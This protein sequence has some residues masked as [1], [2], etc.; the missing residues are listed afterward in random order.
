MSALMG[1]LP[2]VAILSLDIDNVDFRFA[3]EMDFTGAV[4]NL[5]RTDFL[6]GSTTA[7]FVGGLAA[8]LL[9]L[10]DFNSD[11]LFANMNIPALDVG[12]SRL[13]AFGV[14]LDVAVE[15]GSLNTERLRNDF[16]NSILRFETLVFTT[17]TSILLVDVT[18]NG[19]AGMAIR[20]AE[21]C[22]WYRD[23]LVKGTIAARATATMFLLLVFFPLNLLVHGIY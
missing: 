23:G 7:N 6:L 15:V 14:N 3:I 1:L 12:S 10:K 9:R 20:E 17:E 16:N 11:L 21:M 8:F 13:N 2:V 18:A 19:F 4:I 5:G 22:A